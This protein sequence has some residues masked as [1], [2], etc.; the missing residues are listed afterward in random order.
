MKYKTMKDLLYQLNLEAIEE[1]EFG[2][3]KE[4]MY[5]RGIQEAIKRIKE[6]CKQNNIKL[7]L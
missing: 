3:S 5:G 2:N 6:Y 7:N 1:I 4:K